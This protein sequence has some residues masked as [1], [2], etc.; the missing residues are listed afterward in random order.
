MLCPRLCLFPGSPLPGEHLN[1]G[2]GGIS[3]L[4]SLVSFAITYESKKHKSLKLPNGFQTFDQ[5]L[6]RTHFKEKKDLSFK[7]Q[8]QVLEERRG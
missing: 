8:T 2:E 7:D 5:I 6:S 4:Y 3:T 1:A